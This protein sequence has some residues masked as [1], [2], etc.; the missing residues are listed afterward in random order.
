MIPSTNRLALVGFAGLALFGLAATTGMANSATSSLQCGVA[1]STDG[2]MLTIEGTL[3]SPV[4]LTGEYRFSIRST[5]NG[6]S[7]NINQGG[8]FT[9]QANELTPIGRVTVNAGASVDIAFDVTADGEKV[10]CSGDAAN[11]R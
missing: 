3:L 2:G 1:T 4:A 8:M 10:D 11:L 9:A 6:G 5:S 7:S